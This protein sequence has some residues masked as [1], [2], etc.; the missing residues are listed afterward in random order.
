MKCPIDGGTVNWDAGLDFYVCL[1]CRE[2]LTPD[3]LVTRA[4]RRTR[5]A[6]VKSNHPTAS[7]AWLRENG[8]AR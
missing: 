7:R 4:T 6:Y 5:R 8:Y 3:E 2:M 1:A